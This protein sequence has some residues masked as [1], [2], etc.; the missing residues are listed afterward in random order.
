MRLGGWVGGGNGRERGYDLI[1]A[2]LSGS[3]K[4]ILPTPSALFLFNLHSEEYNT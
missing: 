3:N 4:S 1:W 2:Y